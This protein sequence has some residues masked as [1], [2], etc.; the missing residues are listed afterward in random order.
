MPDRV[1]ESIEDLL[2]RWSF[3]HDRVNRFGRNGSHQKGC[4][5][6]CYIFRAGEGNDCAAVAPGQKRSILLGHAPAYQGAQVF[7]I[8]GSLNMYGSDLRPVEN[9]VHEPMLQIAE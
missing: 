1:G 4:G 7:V 3:A 2:H 5:D 8:R 9:V 6:P